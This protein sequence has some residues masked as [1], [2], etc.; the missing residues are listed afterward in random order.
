MSLTLFFQST[1]FRG[2][3]SYYHGPISVHH[4]GLPAAPQRSDRPRTDPRK[5]CRQPSG[6]T[7]KRDDQPCG[8]A[9][10]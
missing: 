8:T 4:A 2:A 1:F 10:G 5:L 9:H 6:G 3:G 7:A